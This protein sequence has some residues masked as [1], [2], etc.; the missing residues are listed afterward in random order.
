MV[1]TPTL[2]VFLS[3]TMAAALQP[4]HNDPN[5]SSLYPRTFMNDFEYGDSRYPARRP[6]SRVVAQATSRPSSKDRMWQQQSANSSDSQSSRPTLDSP[7][8][9]APRQSTADSKALLPPE[10]QY[11]LRSSARQDQRSPEHL[12]DPYEQ[13]QEN[14]RAALSYSLPSSTARRVAET[15]D[16]GQRVPSRGSNELNQPLIESHSA[17]ETMTGR[18]R[19]STPTVS[20]VTSPQGRVSPNP[21]N[22]RPPNGQKTP[23][24][25]QDGI[26]SIIP[27]SASANY[28]PPIAPN[29]RTYPQQPTYV[30]QSNANN[31]IQPVYTPILPQPE[32]VCVECAMRDQDMADVDVTSPGV[33]ERAS[34]ADFEQLKKREL[35]EEAAGIVNDDPNRPRSKG[36]RLTEQNVKLWL[37]IV[38][39][40]P[41]FSN[42]IAEESCFYI[43]IPGNL[44]QSNKR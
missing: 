18:N 35:E 23:P 8:V 11:P 34:D 41:F 39:L 10:N 21:S 29:H 20:R 14:Q 1:H 36:G 31:L 9:A 6:Q 12:S 42:R 15:Y 2:H 13:Q 17:Q 28:T 4:L 3:F 43:R 7:Q 16:S 25:I 19:P 32:E 37:S 40:N 5:S 26:P 33:W 27:L 24:L 38:C 22:S 44:H 30:N